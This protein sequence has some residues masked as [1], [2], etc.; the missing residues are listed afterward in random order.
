MFVWTLLCLQAELV[1]APH[2]GRQAAKTTFQGTSQIHHGN[3]HSSSRV[4]LLIGNPNHGE[5]LAL[6]IASG[7]VQN[8]FHH[9]GNPERLR[10]Y[11]SATFVSSRFRHGIPWDS[12][13]CELSSIRWSASSFERR[14]DQLLVPRSLL[15][16]GFRKKCCPVRRAWHRFLSSRVMVVFCPGRRMFVIFSTSTH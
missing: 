12:F 5:A 3:W 6:H 13:K 16:G 4:E 2:C 1:S 9:M 8:A 15:L 14:L 7:G 11:L 10:P